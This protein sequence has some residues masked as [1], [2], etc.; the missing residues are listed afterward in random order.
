MQCWCNRVIYTHCSETHT[1]C[2]ACEEESTQ[3]YK[4]ALLSLSRHASERH[5]KP[6]NRPQTAPFFPQVSVTFL[7]KHSPAGM[8]PMWR[9]HGCNMTVGSCS[10]TPA[11][12]WVRPITPCRSSLN[13]P[14]PP[15]QITLREKADWDVAHFCGHLFGIYKTTEKKGTDLMW[16]NFLQWTIEDDLPIKPG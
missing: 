16:Y 10:E 4:P 1:I 2:R 9:S 15:T 7:C 14:S 11:S 6:I 13:I 8:M 5:T 12:C 3:K